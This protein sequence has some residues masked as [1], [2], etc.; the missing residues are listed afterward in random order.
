MPRVFID[1]FLYDNES[2]FSVKLN[3]FDSQDKPRELLFF[4]AISGFIHQLLS[5][6]FS[7]GHEEQRTLPPTNLLER[8]K[9]LMGLVV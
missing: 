9:P 1:P 2:T 8:E 4:S 7:P 3:T 5:N 6:T